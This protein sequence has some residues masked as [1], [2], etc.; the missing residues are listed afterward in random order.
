EKS[1]G[2]KLIQW[3]LPGDAV[4]TRVIMPDAS[5]TEGLGES[6]LTQLDPGRVI[7]LV[8]FGF[9]RVEAVSK[10]TVNLVFSHP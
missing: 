5:L 7:Q 2:V 10:S 8:R 3:V 9:C 1:S 4:E 6:P